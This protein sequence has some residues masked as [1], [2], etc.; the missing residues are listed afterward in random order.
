MVRKRWKEWNLPDSYLQ[1]ALEHRESRKN[2]E[3]TRAF[4]QYCSFSSAVEVAKYNA[5]QCH[6][7]IVWRMEVG[8]EGG[9]RVR[10]MD[11]FWKTIWIE[12]QVGMPFQIGGRH[13]LGWHKVLPLTHLFNYFFCLFTFSFLF[14]CDILSVDLAAF[15]ANYV[16]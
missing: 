14:Y 6:L 8:I 16:Q 7:G 15:T 1:I 9:S 11:V 10:L 3:K 5:G 4:S 2:R 12:E 13:D